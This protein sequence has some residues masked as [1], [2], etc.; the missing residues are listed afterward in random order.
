MSGPMSVRDVEDMTFQRREW[1]TE[2][3]WWT[4]L[5]VL[6]LASLLGAFSGG[7]LSETTAGGRAAGVEVKYERFVRHSGMATWTIRVQ[8]QAVENQKA[9][10]FVS[11]ELT[12][13]MQ[14]QQVSPQPST[15][16]STRAGTTYEFDAKATSPPVVRVTFRPDA[17]GAREGIVR[18]GDAAGT[19]LW[20]LFYP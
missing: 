17:I 20:L 18:G 10:V 7:P 2:R 4:V 13:A 1:A 8:P 9:S 14:I 16:I 15:E 3:V 5:A 12:Q 19:R 6:V 11:D